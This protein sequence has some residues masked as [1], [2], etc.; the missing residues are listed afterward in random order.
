M[1]PFAVVASG[2]A[3]L[4]GVL[5]ALL[6]VLGM[7]A[8]AAGAPAALTDVYAS[9]RRYDRAT[10]R[11][12][13]PSAAQLDDMRALVTAVA[14]AVRPGPPSAALV[15]QAKAAGFVLSEAVDGGGPLWVLHEPAGVRAG[16]GLYAFRPRGQGQPICIQA[17]HTFFDQGT[18]DIA[19]ALF[20]GLPADCLFVNTVH[21]H[22]PA[23]GPVDADDEHPADVA[24]GK[25]TW[26]G[27][28][29]AGALAAARFAI[30]QVHGFGAGQDPVALQG[31]RAIVADGQKTRAS[32]APAVR[33][34][35]ALAARLPP[36]ESVRLYGV[37][38]DVLGATTNVQGKA[39]R[40]AGSI[41]LHVEMS[42]DTRR[43]L[44]ADVG[45][46]STAL[47]ETLL[48]P[49]S[50]GAKSAGKHVKGQR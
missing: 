39:A 49:A 34:R 6:V 25:A 36:P 16:G 33:L 28:A 38:A 40:A 48:A 43:A 9:A 4:T 27:A 26:F 46:L 15:A 17:P 32:D 12:K 14:Q 5:A 31:V 11:W 21:R 1:M 23:A 50:A 47:R 3:P 22:S 10:F 37:D 18:G 19:L 41:F 2:V 44:G 29:N 8:T 42:A 24:H 7:S 45:P 13:S 30:V 20:A 35:A